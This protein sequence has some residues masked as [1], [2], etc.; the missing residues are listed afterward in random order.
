V[1]QHLETLAGLIEGLAAKKDIPQI[2]VA[3]GEKDDV[4]L[5]F[6]HLTPLTTADQNALKA[7]GE[8]HPCRIY[9]Q[10]KGPDSIHKIWPETGSDLLHYSLPEF[11]LRFEFHPSDFTQVNPELNQRMVSQAMTLLDP[12]SSDTILDLFCGLGN[13]TLPIARKAKKVVGIEGSDAMVARAKA[14]ASLNQ[15]TNTDFYVADLFQPFDPSAWG[16]HPFNKVLLDP[17]RSGAQ[18]VVEQIEKINPEKILYIS[19]NPATFA[20][21][22]GILVHEKHY[23]LLKAG[24]MDMF[25]HTSHVESMALF[26]RKS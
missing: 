14:N 3:I 10:P 16:E 20:R 7:F 4:A 19:C 25:P 23:T 15:I 17:P 1:G 8:K 2:E 12:T 22:A 9:L 11:N 24:I 18:A 26:Q 21:D 6:R 13:F 5:V